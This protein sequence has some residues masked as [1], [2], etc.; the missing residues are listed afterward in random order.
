VHGLAALLVIPSGLAAQDLV[1]S[2]EIAQRLQG[3]NHVKFD[4][5]HQ[6]LITYRDAHD[7]TE[8]AVAWSQADGLRS[9]QIA[10]LKDFP[11]VDEFNILSAA[12]MGDGVVLAGILQAGEWRV[13]GMPRYVILTYDLGGALRSL[14]QVNPYLPLEIAADRDG[15]VYALGRRGG[16]RPATN[17]VIKYSPSGAVEREFLS[18]RFLEG[19]TLTG[20][21]PLRGRNLMWVDGNHLNVYLAGPQEFFQFDPGGTLQ[22]RVSLRDPLTRLRAD[23][24]V[25]MSLV[26]YGASLL[27]Q[28]A[29]SRNG[30]WSILLAR[31]PMKGGPPT[32]LQPVDRELGTSR[33]PLV[34]KSGQAMLFLNKYTG[35]IL[36]R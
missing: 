25:I 16:G 35:T 5:E 27:M 9:G 17:L 7:K 14:W 13:R 36:R 8:S 28:V 32:V 12:A 31:V 11:N 22:R 33:V 19:D 3:G 29:I 10:P 6:V 24:A 18:S 26:D 15:S 23:R 20:R 30:E 21:D 2:D 1:F 4:S 34:G